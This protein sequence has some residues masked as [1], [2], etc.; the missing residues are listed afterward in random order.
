MGSLP[1]VNV[2]ADRAPW[3]PPACDCARLV[4]LPDGREVP[5]WGRRWSCASCGLDKQRRLALMCSM[6]G[7]AY[8]LTLTLVPLLMVDDDGLVLVPDRHSRCD[9]YSHQTIFTNSRGKQTVRWLVVPNC[10]HCSS[11][12]S[13]EK[14]KWRKRLRRAVPG[15]QMLDVREETKA[16][17]VHI[18]L[19]VVGL[20]ENLPASKGGDWHPLIREVRRIWPH[21]FIDGA[22][23]RSK[24]GGGLGWYLGKYLTKQNVRMARGYRRWNRTRGFAPEVVMDQWRRDQELARRLSAAHRGTGPTALEEPL[25]PGGFVVGIG[26][27]PELQRLSARIALGASVASPP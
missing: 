12:L 3:I 20:P 4:R 9:R 15:A 14:T 1:T 24:H 25:M 11:W 10:Q 5:V 22:P 17:M 13:A 21:G 23:R 26:R 8:L 18:H 19:A 16:G 27:H 7:P 6:A 2:D